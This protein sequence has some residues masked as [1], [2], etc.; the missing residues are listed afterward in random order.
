MLDRFRQEVKLA[1]RVTSPHVVRTFDLGEH[2]GEHFLTMEIVEGRSL[3]QLLDDGPL[4][5][6]EILRISRAMAA[7]I[8]AAHANGVTH[9]DL[10]PD[11][12]LVGKD[13]RIAITDFGIARAAAV[14]PRE[15]VEGFVGTPAYMSPEQVEGADTIGP[16]TDV[17]AFGA[18]LFEMLAG[19][20]PFVGTDL[21][22]VA[23]ARLREAPPDPRLFRR[24]PDSLA[25]LALRCMARE[26]AQR[27]AD[28]GQLAKALATV[29]LDGTSTLINAA[30]HRVPAKSARSVAILP[31]RASGDLVEVADGLSEEIVDAL[32]MTRDLRVR[33]LV[34]SRK[35]ASTDLDSRE[36]GK[37][38]GVDVVVDG[39]IRKRGAAAVRIAARVIGVEDGFQ[40]W[41]NHFDTSPDDLFAAGDQVVRAIAKAL[42]VELAVPQR[43]K[44]APEIADVY[45]ESKAKLRKGWLA[46]GVEDL[47]EPLE[48]AHASVPDDPGI[49][50]LLSLVHGRSAF[51]GGK[52][53]LPRARE[54]AER[55][56]KLAPTSGEAWLALGVAA[57]N[58][59]DMATST[60]ALIEACEHAPG[61]ALAQALLGAVA[62]EAGH[63]EGAL[64]HLEGA[65]SLDP[66]GPQVAD[67]PRAYVYAGREDD[68]FR[69]LEAQK[70][71]F[72]RVSIARFK[73]WRGEMYDAGSF[74]PSQI[75]DS[76][77]KYAEV[78]ARIHRGRTL[79]P[80]DRETLLAIVTDVPNPR[81]RA[82]RAQFVSEFFLFVGEDD[83]AMETIELAVTN[84]LQ[85]HLW[86]QK[87]PLL[88]RVR[89]RLRFSELAA[90]VA[91]RARIVTE[92]IERAEH[93]EMTAS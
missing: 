86:M 25:E 26:P 49:L 20:R 50:A 72:R 81:L 84:G 75:P 67:L 15:T 78:A 10:K 27:F 6:D 22:A 37:S 32:S 73:M 42:T 76:F 39:S 12:I 17:Y 63:M 90:I 1:R 58:A 87:C 28:G 82:T 59:G 9:R 16:A 38:L 40:L 24:M 46:G 23:V 83:A 34:S 53:A 41:A 70:I 18:I 92:V 33:P 85:D 56:T 93:P 79:A 91:E 64:L 57:L 3:A 19:R 52:G 36:I 68:A 77:A 47:F 43:A 11:N 69:A 8:A 35:S 44:I 2:A 60:R 66:E 48:A 62:L 45:L 5:V 74:K 30:P 13:G 65:Q 54:L 55:A 29:Q 31:L 14:S 51:Y 61:L 88:D 4:A 89:D 21:I 71:E 7:G 80:G